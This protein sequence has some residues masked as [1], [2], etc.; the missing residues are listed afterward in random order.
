MI[1]H[2]LASPGRNARGE[3]T[4]GGEQKFWRASRDLSC[5]ELISSI[6]RHVLNE[7]PDASYMCMRAR[8][9]V[10]A[11]LGLLHETLRP[12]RAS[13]EITLSG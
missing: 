6:V 11:P 10:P 1:C 5:D 13:R 3:G 7:K 4:L 12:L 2:D 9:R 8:A